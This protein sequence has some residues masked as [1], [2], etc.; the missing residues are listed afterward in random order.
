MRTFSD[1]RYMLRAGRSLR[2]AA[3]VFLVTR[4]IFVIVAYAAVVLASPRAALLPEKSRPQLFYDALTG[5]D[6]DWYVAVATRGYGEAGINPETSQSTR[7]FFPLLP[8]LISLGEAAGLTPEAAGLIA[9]NLAFF[10]GLYF[11]HRLFAY[12]N[13]E[14]LANR[15][16]WVAGAAPFSGVFSMIYPES[17][18]LA[19]SAAAF[20]YYEKRRPWRMGVAAA[21]AV[22]AR[23]N[24][25]AVAAVLT[26]CVLAAIYRSADKLKTAFGWAPA[27]VLPVLAM[28]GWML[29]LAKWAGDPLAFIDAKNAWTEVSL[30]ALIDP[31][32]TG[33]SVSSGTALHLALG[34]GALCIVVSAARRIPAA[35]TALWLI[36]VGPALV[37]GLVGFG[38]YAWTVF[39]V[40]GATG[41][42]LSR[43][44]FAGAVLY[45]IGV[46]FALVTVGIFQWRLVP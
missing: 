36:Y 19:S 9:S 42:T 24:G 13:G 11:S 21:L 3:V 32:D 40:F 2:V 28:G 17:L 4:V 20:Y 23:P 12:R 33:P 18:L 7:A 38:R 41:V 1:N 15:A 44:R 29:L 10:V 8:W 46:A 27:V 22:L 14:R 25:F 43:S 34:L 26:F 16:V 30:K 31:T 45:G 37:L 6:G 39:P 35:W 5:W